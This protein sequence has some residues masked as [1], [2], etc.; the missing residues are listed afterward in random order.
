MIPVLKGFD[1]ATAELFVDQLNKERLRHKQQW[2]TYVGTVA[3]RSVS[4]K[5]FDTGHLQILRVDGLDHGSYHDQKV[6]DWKRV[7]V[8]AINRNQR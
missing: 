2:I 7:I 5:S 6:S 8:E 1:Y 3:G 4:L